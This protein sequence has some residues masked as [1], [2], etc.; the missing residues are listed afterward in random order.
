MMQQRIGLATPP[1]RQTAI[2][3]ASTTSAASVVSLH[4]TADSAPGMQVENGDDARP[5]FSVPGS[6]EIGQPRLVGLISLEIPVRNVCGDHRAFAIILR[7]STPLGP[8]PLR[9]QPH[10]AV[11]PARSAR[12]PVLEHI[13]PDAAGAIGLAARL[14][15]VVVEFRKS[16]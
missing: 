7:L 12:K 9:I 15:E 14:A 4:W 16:C 5:A 1:D 6:G 2:I 3:S 8:R 11:A 10:Q 13:A